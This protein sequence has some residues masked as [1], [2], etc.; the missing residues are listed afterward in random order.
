MP[1][2]K[3][4]LSASKTICAYV[5]SLLLKSNGT[6]VRCVEGILVPSVVFDAA[7]S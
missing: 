4:F 2:V 3:G 1:F 7:D 6:D 5:E